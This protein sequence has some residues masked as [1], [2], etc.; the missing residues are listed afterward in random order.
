MPADPSTLRSPWK[1]AAACGIFIFI[2]GASVRGR[3]NPHDQI[4]ELTYG[5]WHIPVYTRA[6]PLGDAL[7][8]QRRVA[9]IGEVFKGVLHLL[10]LSAFAILSFKRGP[11]LPPSPKM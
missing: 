4:L 3:I 5:V 7:S 1:L 11:Y 8:I 9:F 6:E 2:L 10:A